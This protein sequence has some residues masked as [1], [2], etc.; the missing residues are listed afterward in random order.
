MQRFWNTLMKHEAETWINED[1]QTMVLSDKLA[2]YKEVEKEL[3]EARF[4][5][6]MTPNSHWSKPLQGRLYNMEIVLSSVTPIP[7]SKMFFLKG[8]LQAM[9]QTECDGAV[10][11]I[12]ASILIAASDGFPKARIYSCENYF[13][14]RANICGKLYTVD[15]INEEKIRLSS[16]VTSIKAM[17]ASEL[18]VTFSFK[19]SPEPTTLCITPSSWSKIKIDG[20]GNVWSESEPDNYVTILTDELMRL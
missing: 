1:Y 4:K 13:I 18:S 20:N 2:A 11:S 14:R 9:S 15:T 19:G 7:I 17:Y 16:T 12:M 3:Q 10:A 5:E 6:L 8:C